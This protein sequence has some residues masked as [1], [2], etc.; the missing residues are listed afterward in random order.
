MY[1]TNQTGVPADQEADGETSSV[2]DGFNGAQQQVQHTRVKTKNNRCLAYICCAIV[3]VLCIAGVAFVI[4]MAR[5][6]S[7]GLTTFG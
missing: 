2:D 6:G 3:F 5:A 7:G 4:Q 1:S